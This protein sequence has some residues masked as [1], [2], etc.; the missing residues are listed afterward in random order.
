M[1]GTREPWATLP[2]PPPPS[3]KNPMI[4]LPRGGVLHVGEGRDSARG[5]VVPLL[6]PTPYPEGC[7]LCHFGWLQFGGRSRAIGFLL[8][9][10]R[11]W[12]GCSWSA[13]A[14]FSRGVVSGSFLGGLSDDTLGQVLL[15]VFVVTSHPRVP[16]LVC[17][18][19]VASVSS[20]SA[21]S[22]SAKSGLLTSSTEK[23]GSWR[24]RR[25]YVHFWSPL[26]GW[27]DFACQGIG[28][29]D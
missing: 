2:P 28:W 24:G 8:F 15:E 4:P 3:P 27:S 19:A 25:R 1:G 9:G 20:F 29:H 23:A 5:K 7:H 18:H 26:T 21:G 14:T 16:S 17:S 11:C 13:F 6:R 22:E 12:G 10:G